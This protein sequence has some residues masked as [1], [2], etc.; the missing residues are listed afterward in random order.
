[1]KAIYNEGNFFAG[2]SYEIASL[3]EDRPPILPGL[4]IAAF[5]TLLCIRVSP[6]QALTK[7]AKIQF[8]FDISET[9][10]VVVFCWKI[11]PDLGRH[12]SPRAH[13][14]GKWRYNAQDHF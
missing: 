8:E 12:G 9:E 4:M 14:L 1:M 2:K 6:L 13:T 10:L 11:G 3:A 7:G 5:D